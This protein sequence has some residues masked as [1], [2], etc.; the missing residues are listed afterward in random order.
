[1]KAG[2]KVYIW[3]CARRSRIKSVVKFLCTRIFY[4][5]RYYRALFNISSPLCDELTSS[6]IPP[7]ILN[8]I[9]IVLSLMLLLSAS[10][11]LLLLCAINQIEFMR[12]FMSIRRVWK[13]R[14]GLKVMILE[15]CFKIVMSHKMKSDKSEINLNM[16]F[17]VGAWK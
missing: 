15:I 3:I 5:Y 12:F 11:L 13:M 16:F 9:L 8:K 2:D 14:E 1:M 17:F 7:T 10:L 4:C 6:L